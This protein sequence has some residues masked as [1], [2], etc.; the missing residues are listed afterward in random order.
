[1][2]VLIVHGSQFGTTEHLAHDMADAI[3]ALHEVEVVGAH[4]AES[5]T[6]A[7]IDLL[8]V[9]APTQFKGHRLLVRRFLKHLESH[10]FTGCAAA[11]FDTRAH[12][13]RGRTGSAAESIARLLSE[14]GCNILVPAESFTVEGMRGPLEAGEAERARTWI[15]G[16]V[17]SVHPV[18]LPA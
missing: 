7:G 6:G 4:E 15:G 2:R 14:A 5:L 11:A 17:R 16:L 9:G 3:S 12:G 1:M 13:D 8:V 18:H 10:G